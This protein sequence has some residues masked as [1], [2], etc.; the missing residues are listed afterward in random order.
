[1]AERRGAVLRAVAV[2]ESC[3]RHLRSKWLKPITV[4]G[5]R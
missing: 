1:M 2:K 3:M 4:M 5:L